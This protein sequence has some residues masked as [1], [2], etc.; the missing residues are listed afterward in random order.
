MTR[1]IIQSKRTLLYVK[2][3]DNGWLK[4]TSNQ[5]EA[6]RYYYPDLARLELYNSELDTTMYDVVPF[7]GV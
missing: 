5:S 1:Y 7:K 4:M 2:N 3:F 6:F